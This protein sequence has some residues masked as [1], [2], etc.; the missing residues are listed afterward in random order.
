M[1]YKDKSKRLAAFN[2]WYRRHKDQHIKKVHRDR[3]LLMR[4]G[5]A[6]LVDKFGGKC[7]LCG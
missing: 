2:R 3:F 4:K 5:K 7:A 1:P 6:E